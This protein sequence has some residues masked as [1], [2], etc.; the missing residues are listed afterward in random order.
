M[1]QNEG[2][3]LMVAGTYQNLGM[4]YVDSRNWDAAMDCFD[5]GFGIAQEFGFLE[6]MAKIYWA[7]AEMML[8]WE[9]SSTAASLC[10]RGLKL[11]KKLGDR[12]MEG[13]AYR[14]MG[15]VFTL[16]KDWSKA[17]QMFQDALRLN[18]EYNDPQTEAEAYRD[19]GK[20]HA[21]KGD[22]DQARSSF[23]TALSGFRKLGAMADRPRRESRG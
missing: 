16:R 19:M 9:D 10:E 20:M 12:Q 8:E 6:V 23:E 14:L 7:R 1:Y 18:K 15:R 21:A 17:E 2:N 3:D 5:R 13:D 4:T 11:C 22:V